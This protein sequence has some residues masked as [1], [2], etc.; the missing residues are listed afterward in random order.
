MAKAK[1]LP[2]GSW[3]VLVYSHTDEN[4]KRKYESFTAPSKKEAEYL[5]AEFAAGKSEKKSTILTT[6]NDAIDS[7]IDSKSNI[8]SPSTIRGYRIMQRNAFPE[9]IN[10][11]V[12]ELE[13]GIAIQRQ[14]N[15]NAVNYSSKSIRNQIGL[16]S[17]VLKH[18]GMECP[19]VA[20]PPKKP[21][22]IDVPSMNDIK[23][24]IKALEGTEIECQILLALTCS[25]RQSE[26][27][28]LTA[29]DVKIP[30]VHIHGARVPNEFNELTYK[31]TAKSEAGTRSVL[32]TDRLSMLMEE[33][34][35]LCPS[36]WLFDTSPYMLL[37][38]FKKI[39]KNNNIK[40]YTIHSL[41]HGFAAIMH[42]QGVPDKYVLEMG[43]WSSDHVLRS[44]YQ[45]TFDSEVEAAKKRV[46]SFFDNI[47]DNDS[48]NI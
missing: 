18:I 3:R 28:A 46:N 35:R 14:I 13:N 25:L 15:E 2:S 23:K 21:T 7:Y 36:G 31:P 43:G 37:D 22:Q 1:K 16:I 44:V 41:R 34:C 12:S 29:D 32:M 40:Q 11:P 38:K 5:A 42:A 26:I 30:Y 19:A 9:L 45:Y 24:I 39:L 17:A 27:L 20:A 47:N 8:L 33:K 48:N 6:F 4:G 10:K